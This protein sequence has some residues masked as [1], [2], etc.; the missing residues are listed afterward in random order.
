ML[1]YI[2]VTLT[3]GF[4]ALIAFL[5]FFKK[6]QFEDCEEVKYQIFHEKEE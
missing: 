2:V 5:F 1:P 4:C 3:S 6:G